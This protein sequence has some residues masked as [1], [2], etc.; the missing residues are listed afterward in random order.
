M[1]DIALFQ[2]DAFSLSS[3]S[4]AI[5]EQPYV[6]GRIGTLGLFEEDGITTTTI[7]IERDGDTL[8]LVASG[9]RGAP[10]AVVAGSKRNMIPFNT[11]H[12][13]QRGVIM[14]DEIAN[15]R[16]FGSET[17]LEALQTVVN[18][19][20]AK[21]RKQL[22]ATH[23]FHRIGAI[24]GAVLD[25]DGKTVLIDL[26][27]YFGIEQTV[28]PFEL[29]TATTEIRQKCV[30]VQDAIE[31][32]LGAMTYTG[33]RVLCGREF[34]NKLIVA[35]SVKETYLASVMAAQLRGDARDAFDFGGCT[36]ERYRGR[37]GDVGYV[38][39]DEAHAVPEGVSDLFITRFAPADYVEAVNTTGIPY[40]AKQEL[41]PFGKGVEIE[42]QSN[43]IHLC[44][45]P[46][47]L[48]KLKA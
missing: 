35:K 27:K 13:P 10:A 12:L 18:R 26:L 14:A 46:K 9:Q 20:L 24:K 4:A 6:P 1:A 38:A 37:V 40:Y 17:E 25:A 3:L 48:V 43:P 39:D 8:S 33:V 16:A 15:L 41:M 7:Q 45:R 36:F 34:W 32:A 5:N 31:D 47:A 22:D 29:S 11:V 44:T 2:D 30:E 21:M 42:A 23:E 19:R 28:I